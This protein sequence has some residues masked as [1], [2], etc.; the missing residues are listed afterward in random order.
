MDFNTMTAKEFSELIPRDVEKNKEFRKEFNSIIEKSPSLQKVFWSWCRELPTIAFDVLFYTLNPQNPPNQRNL[1]FILWGKQPEAVMTLDERI[2]T[3]TDEEQKNVGINKSRKEGATEIVAK[4]FSLHCML[5][6]HSNFIVGS[7]KKELVDKFGDDYTIFSKIDNVFENLPEWTGFRMTDSNKN[8]FRKDMLIRINNTKSTITGETTND[9]FSAGGRS[10][11]AFLDEIGRVEKSIADSIDG[12]IHDVTNCVIYGSTHWLGPGHTFNIVLGK[13]STK[14]ITLLWPD[15]PKKNPGV[16]TSPEPGKIRLLDLA[17]YKK[18]CP[19]LPEEFELEKYKKIILESE[20]SFVADGCKGLPQPLRSPW[21]DKQEKER[22]K[23]DFWC[24][25]WAEPFGS[26]ETVFDHVVLKEI[27][28]KYVRKP[29]FEG[30]L[31][32]DYLSNGRVDIESI[33]FWKNA[34]EKRLKWW[35]PLPNGRPIQFHNYIIGGDISLGLGSSNSVGA[36]YDVNTNELV[37]EWADANTKP[38]DFA[39]FEVALALW[40][41][42]IKRPLLIWES[43]GGQGVN[44]GRRVTWQNYH[45]C[46]VQTIEDGISRK[47]GKKF[48]WRSSAQSKSDLF[49]E[50][51]IALSEGLK[52]ERNYKSIIVYSGALVDE[53]FDYVFSKGKEMY[54]SRKSDESTGARER[55]GDRTIATALCVLGLRDQPKGRKE[56][57]V[58]PPYNSFMSRF[59]ERNKQLAEERTEFTKRY[60]Y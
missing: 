31:I 59:L 46:Y 52:E 11:G 19:S 58:N 57:V 22:D 18:F 30:E 10:T 50:L 60:L 40:V 28:E 13:E 7:R 2:K 32:F 26:S 17:Y 39:D 12:S 51:K 45:N 37:G 15:N 1:P 16:Y 38:E 9:N 8:I 34:G 43:N 24:N 27:K 3:A 44:F 14:V 33:K 21:H 25:V 6:P 49:E 36:V 53:L 54:P 4:L 23:R 42:G 55:H 20:L 35:G 29:D 41:G 47:R 5:Y 56:D 48:G